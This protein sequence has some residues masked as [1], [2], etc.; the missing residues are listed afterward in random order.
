[1]EHRMRDFLEKAI[2][3]FGSH[4]DDTR[5]EDSTS[6]QQLFIETDGALRKSPNCHNTRSSTIRLRSP[7][8]LSHNSQEGT[9]CSQA[10][11]QVILDAQSAKP[12]PEGG[13]GH[14]E[15]SQDQMHMAKLLKQLT[16]ILMKI[17]R[18]KAVHQY[19]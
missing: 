13:L 14:D 18:L 5:L 11:L 10:S 8:A 12:P 17:V 9:Q 19:L 2:R 1:M 6:S 16:V 4:F 3:R 15:S 7:Q